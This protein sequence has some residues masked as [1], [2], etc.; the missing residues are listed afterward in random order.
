MTV[1][2]ASSSVS[3]GPPPVLILSLR[4]F[5]TAYLVLAFRFSQGTSTVYIIFG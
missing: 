2:T 1:L 3:A 5:A 4:S